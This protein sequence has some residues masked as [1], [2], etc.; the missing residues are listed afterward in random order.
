MPLHKGDVVKCM[1]GYYTIESLVGS[2]GLGRVW[3]ARADDGT[4]VAIK[5]PLTGTSQDELNLEKLQVEA[6][7]LERL[8]GRKPLLL[9]D[10]SQAYKLDSALR[11]HIVPFLD[12]DRKP[13][14]L[15]VL[16]YLDGASMDKKFRAS[17][18]Q[19]VLSLEQADEYAIIILR[20][21]MAL[22]ENNIL[23]R[24]ISPH[25][26]ISTFRAD[27][28]PVFID[29]GTAK[30]GYNQLAAS[31]IAESVI[32]HFGYSAPE[33]NLGLAS[34]SSDLYSVAATI[35]FLY[36][37]TSPQYLM[38][39]KLLLDE[40]HKTI[41]RIP[42]ERRQI[43]KK[44]LSYYPGD[45]YQTAEDMLN[46]L[47][48]NVVLISEPHIVASGRK[49]PIKGLMVIGR[50]HQCPLPECRRKGFS[51][52]PNIMV[53]DPERY[54]GKHHAKVQLDRKNVCWIEDIDSVS[55]TAIR[56][57]TGHDFE[58]LKPRRGYKLMNGDIVA[59]AYSPTKGPY[60]TI[61]YHSK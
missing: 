31:A 7:V 34:P 36:T 24:D 52:P 33:L 13:P 27:T 51:S 25:N 5:E 42:E 61:S 17:S 1:R 53:N 43:L 29:F 48:G 49:H 45:R 56:K 23:H 60:M 59:L 39:S 4:V 18:N 6:V 3:K 32:Q 30:E 50:A 26:I 44:G 15:L 46:A 9:S 58:I 37:G 35:L 57:A 41:Q 20:V 16:Q 22:H 19:P 2:G 55:H 28:D 14:G 38:T 8:T 47:G 11:T 10:D 40:N 54:V 21:T 12:V